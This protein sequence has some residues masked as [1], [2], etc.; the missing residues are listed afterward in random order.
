MSLISAATFSEVLRHTNRKYKDYIEIHWVFFCI[1]IFSYRNDI[2]GKS[3][4]RCMCWNHPWRLGKLPNLETLFHPTFYNHR[5]ILPKT[6]HHWT[7]T[8]CSCSFSCRKQN[9]HILLLSPFVADTV[10]DLFE[11]WV[12]FW[13]FIEL[14]IF[15]AI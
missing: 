15:F 10:F 4:L 13:K 1:L 5:Y 6:I 12:V 2:I 9:T 14:Y 3:K 7:R 11:I 8:A